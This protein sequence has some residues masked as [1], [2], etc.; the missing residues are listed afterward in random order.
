MKNLP[1]IIM[2]LLIFVLWIIYSVKETFS[3]SGMAIS[4]D[5][6]T[7]LSDV[8]HKPIL[9][10]EEMR[11]DYKNRICGPGRRET[12]DSQTGNYYTQNGMLV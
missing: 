8:Y 6:C 3:I 4:D 2:V 5:Y 12:I 7:K 9:V 10:D 1:I 11:D